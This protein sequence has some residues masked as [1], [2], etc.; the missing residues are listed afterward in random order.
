[1]K[2]EKITYRQFAD[3]AQNDTEYHYDGDMEKD[4]EQSVKTVNE[5]FGKEVFNILSERTYKYNPKR[6]FSQS[7]TTIVVEDLQQGVEFQ[8]RL[9]DAPYDSELNIESS[10]FDYGDEDYE[11]DNVCVSYVPD[12]VLRMYDL[13]G[14]GAISATEMLIEIA[15]GSFY[16]RA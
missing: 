9:S 14:S 16:G 6:K 2:V 5:M 7:V 4:F 1:M 11:W 13:N 8:F 15:S 10:Y 12:H 3:R